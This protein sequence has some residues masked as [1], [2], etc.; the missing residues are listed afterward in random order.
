MTP[1]KY[2][3]G[4][5]D[6]GMVTGPLQLPD[7]PTPSPEKLQNAKNTSNVVIVVFVEK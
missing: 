2:T 1:T 4:D 7:W 6:A 3:P 5:K